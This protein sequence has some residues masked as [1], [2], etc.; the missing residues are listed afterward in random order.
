LADSLDYSH[1]SVV[2][3]INVNFGPTKVSIEYVAAAES[4]LEEEA[5]N[6]KKDLFEKVFEK[7]LVLTW[8]Q[9]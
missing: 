5:F 7:K 4:T 3:K 9:Q 6:K 8:K 2:K 1:R